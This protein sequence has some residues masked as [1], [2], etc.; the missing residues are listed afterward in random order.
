MQVNASTVSHATAA[1]PIHPPA[2][3]VKVGNGE[4]RLLQPPPDKDIS[5]FMNMDAG[6]LLKTVRGDE[7]FSKHMEGVALDQCKVYALLSMA[8]K[9]Q[10]G[11][12]KKAQVIEGAETLADVLG[13]P[14]GNV[15]LHIALPTPATV[16]AGEFHLAFVL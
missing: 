6:T 2:L 13:T 5:Y 9:L 8:K 16:A 12:E 10:P 11:E 14:A 15:F 4:Y 3:L 7:L 1:A